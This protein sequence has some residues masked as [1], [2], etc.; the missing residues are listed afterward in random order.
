MPAKSYETVDNLFLNLASDKSRRI[1]HQLSSFLILDYYVKFN[2][3]SIMPLRC[4]LVSKS[5]S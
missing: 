4:I 2:R 3:Y 1:H 5:S